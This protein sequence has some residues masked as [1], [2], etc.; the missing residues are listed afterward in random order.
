MLGATVS[1]DRYS[2]VGT[3]YYMSPEMVDRQPYGPAVDYWALG[4]LIFEA[5]TGTLPFTGENPRAVFAA[6]RKLNVP[7][8]NLRKAK[9]P[10]LESLVVELLNPNHTERADYDQVGDLWGP[11]ALLIAFL[12]HPSW[13]QRPMRL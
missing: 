2:I 7:W 4:V 12:S 1:Q 3:P 8:Q 13:L 10:L 5:V 6:I 9:D 11:D